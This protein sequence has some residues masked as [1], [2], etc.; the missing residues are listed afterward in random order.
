MD[1][2]KV[3]PPAE[4]KISAV[5]GLVSPCLHRSRSIVFIALLFVAGCADDSTGDV[6]VSGVVDGKE[7][8][9]TAA[10]QREIAEES[11]VLLNTCGYGTLHP[12]GPLIEKVANVL[13]QSHLHLTFAN[14]PTVHLRV[15]QSQS[16][17]GKIDLALQDVDVA[18][19]LNKGFILVH[20]NQETFY[21]SKYSCECSKALEK[22]LKD[23]Q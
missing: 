16:P 19:P 3:N 8:R 1:E 9:L 6:Q 10:A 15:A 17:L 23:A 18:L 13:K 22:T 2:T 21:F 12:D 14:P 4:P 11:I 7:L 20:S 5:K